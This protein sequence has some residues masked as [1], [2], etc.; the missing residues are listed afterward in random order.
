VSIAAK[1]HAKIIEPGDDAL[2]F[3]AIDEK[4]REWR[5]V[6]PHVVQ[7]CVLKA[8]GFFGHCYYPFQLRSQAT[9]LVR[10]LPDNLQIHAAL[11]KGIRGFASQNAA[12]RQ[13]SANSADA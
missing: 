9:D 11:H 8:L 12:K 6:L 2:Q 7:E 10:P 13:G 5:F 4:N 1:Q 3:D